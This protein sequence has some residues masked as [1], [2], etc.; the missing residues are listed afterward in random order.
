MKKQARIIAVI[1]EKGGVN[2]TTAT[3]TLAAALA[4]KGAK[5]LVIDFDPSQGNATYGLISK[6]WDGPTHTKGI[7]S[8]I[9]EGTPLDEVTYSTGRENLHI[10]PSEKFD[11]QKRKYSVETAIAMM[12]PIEGLRSL[13]S[14]IEKSSIRD[15]FDFV[16]IDNGPTSSMAT[17]AAI[18]SSDYFLVACV[19]AS[20]SIDSIESTIASAMQVK[21]LNPKIKPLG[22]FMSSLDKRSADAK[23]AIEK[24]E[25]YSKL[26][27]VYFFK[28]KIPVVEKMK[29]LPEKTK[30]ILEV[31][32]PTERGHKEY[33]EL[34]NEILK[35]VIQLETDST[36][37]SPRQAEL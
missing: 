24:L 32:K 8:A 6:I 30:T 31:T 11:S 4:K 29:F 13:S 16:L 25:D 1:G 3:I 19:A 14:L 34:S 15:E 12:S 17:L 20:F 21:S 37:T 28:S 33:I 10:I 26:S 36:K 18:N 27:G 23:I 35:R 2:K 22:F 7:C 5:T 9:I